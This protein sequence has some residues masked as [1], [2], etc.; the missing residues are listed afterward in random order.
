MRGERGTVRSAKLSRCPLHLRGFQLQQSI[1]ASS[2]LYSFFVTCWEI[3]ALSS[4]LLP[5][6][7]QF[8]CCWC[9]CCWRRPGC[10]S[11]AGRAMMMLTKKTFSKKFI[12][13]GRATWRRGRGRWWRSHRTPPRWS[14]EGVACHRSLWNGQW[15]SL[16]WIFN[17]YTQEKSY[18]PF[19][20][21][22]KNDK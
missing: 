11:S 8:F 1:C 6:R 19:H 12:P 21:K 17:A 14:P 9:R 3:E 7:L 15:P 5:C 16:R 2:D 13:P 10:Q 20:W 18:G 4:T 22:A